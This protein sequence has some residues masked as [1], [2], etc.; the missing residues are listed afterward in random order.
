MTGRLFATKLSTHQKVFT[1]F[2]I[3]SF[4][5]NNLWDVLKIN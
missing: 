2:R 3:H 1:S 4:S 5:E